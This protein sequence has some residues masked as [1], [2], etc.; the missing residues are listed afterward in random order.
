MKL[1][2]PEWNIYCLWYYTNLNST[3]ILGIK[4]FS[5]WLLDIGN[6]KEGDNVNLPENCYP[7][8]QKPITQLYN[9]VEFKDVT[10]SS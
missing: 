4:E 3:A 10:L 6:A 7:E 9:D 1:L 2:L 5:E 8:V